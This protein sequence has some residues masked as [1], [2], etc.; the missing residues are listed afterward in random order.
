MIRITNHSQSKI[1]KLKQTTN[2]KQTIVNLYK[3]ELSK[4]LL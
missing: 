3:N 2:S 4:A 1:N